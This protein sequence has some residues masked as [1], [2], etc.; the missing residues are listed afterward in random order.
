MP[1]NAA[2]F[3]RRAERGLGVA[4][5]E[6]QANGTVA[7]PSSAAKKREFEK[8]GRNASE[9]DLPRDVDIAKK[10]GLYGLTTSEIDRP[11]IFDLTDNVSDEQFEEARV[12]GNP[13]R[14]SPLGSSSWAV[15]LCPL[16]RV[17]AVTRTP[18]SGGPGKSPDPYTTPAAMPSASAGVVVGVPLP[19]LIGQRRP[20][21]R[22]GGRLL[23]RLACP[24]ARSAA[25]LA[26]WH[27]VQSSCRF[28]G[29]SVPPCLMLMM[30]STSWAWPPHRAHRPPSRVRM[31]AARCLGTPRYR[32]G[33]VS[34]AITAARRRCGARRRG[35]SRAMPGGPRPGPAAANVCG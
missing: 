16:S 9:V 28:A 29:W 34:Q 18:D 3:V 4:V 11:G 22:S 14:I 15:S 20:G 25:V 17:F 19:P 31:W 12:E 30:W 27:A 2:E 6:G 24:A 8:P 26:V 1:T 5:R 7:T 35:G 33:A 32:P 21:W 23:L 10:S 13:S